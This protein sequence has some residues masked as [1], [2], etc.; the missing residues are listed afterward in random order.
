MCT[1]A[2]KYNTVYIIYRVH[3]ATCSVDID[4]DMYII[5]IN[6]LISKQNSNHHVLGDFKES[7][8][9]GVEDILILE[10]IKN[11]P[12]AHHFNVGIISMNLAK[13]YIIFHQPGISLK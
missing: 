10:F 8:H 5:Y 1:C 4:V 7:P 12:S 11:R 9:C 13:L 3:I 6:Q 2:Y